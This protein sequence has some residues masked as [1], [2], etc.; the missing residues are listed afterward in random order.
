MREPPRRSYRGQLDAAWPGE[1]VGLVLEHPRPVPAVLPPDLALEQRV[2]DP[3]ADAL[4]VVISRPEVEGP[5][6]PPESIGRRKRADTLTTRD[7]LRADQ[8]T[9]IAHL[10]GEEILI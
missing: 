8:A 9:G 2:V 4:A 7:E 6:A 10:L 3:R 5:E 1:V